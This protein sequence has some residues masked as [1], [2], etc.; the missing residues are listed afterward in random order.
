MQGTRTHK[1]HN[2]RVVYYSLFDDRASQLLPTTM[3]DS[4]ALQPSAPA[5]TKEQEAM[6]TAPGVG[7]PQEIPFVP[8]AAQVAYMPVGAVPGGQ[9]AYMPGSA[10]PIT[11]VV[12]Y[13]NLTTFHYIA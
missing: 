11:I 7:Q 6:G 2:D 1:N 8:G 13:E 9:I 3:E 10:Q 5:L 4:S 12:S